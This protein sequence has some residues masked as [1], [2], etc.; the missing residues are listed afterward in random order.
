V[1]AIVEG[2]GEAL[3]PSVIAARMVMSRGTITEIVDTLERHGLVR[4]AVE[5]SDRRMRAVSV[6]AEGRSRLEAVRPELHRA[7]R[8][9]MQALSPA[10]QAQML[11]FVAAVQAALPQ[12]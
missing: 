6:T 3:L 2:A 4:R 5:G 1:L 12:E 7:E 9:L 10:E 8:R 11:Q